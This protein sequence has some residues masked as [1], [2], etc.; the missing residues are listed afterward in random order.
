MIH[1]RTTTV[2]H[3]VMILRVDTHTRTP[4]ARAHHPAMGKAACYYVASHKVT[5]Y[6]HCLD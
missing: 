2:L 5:S 4:A 1:D 6:M 3:T